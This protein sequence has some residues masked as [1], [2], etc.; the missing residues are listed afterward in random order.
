MPTM[1]Y[2]QDING[3]PEDFPFEMA[4]QTSKGTS[5]T[6][7]QFAGRLVCDRQGKSPETMIPQNGAWYG[8]QGTECHPSSLGGMT[9][10]QR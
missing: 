7:R 6:C 3:V 5:V 1:A 2:G 10:K 9:C 8:T 4:P